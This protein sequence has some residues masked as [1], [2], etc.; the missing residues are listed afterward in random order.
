MAELFPSLL[1]LAQQ[2]LPAAGAEVSAAGATLYGALFRGFPSAYNQQEVLRV[3]HGHLG[4]A[5]RGEASAALGVLLALAQQRL[6][7]GYASFLSSILDHVEGYADAQVEQVYGLFG[8]IVAA[9]CAERDAGGGA[10]GDGSRMEDEL[11]V[12]LRKQLNSTQPGPRRAGVIGAVSLV[13]RLGAAAAEHGAAADET[14]V[15]E[16]CRCTWAADQTLSLSLIASSKHGPDVLLLLPLLHP[17]THP[18]SAGKRYAEAHSMLKNAFQGCKANPESFAFLCDQLTR[19][20]GGE[21]T[22][23]RQGGAPLPCAHAPGGSSCAG[24][25]VETCASLPSL[26]A[27]RCS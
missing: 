23:S 21:K 27:G 14:A 24:N 17:P 22:T 18:L 9:A 4:A 26:G 1:G 6:L 16:A 13:Q 3:L 12:V 8:E 2:L 15:G 5:A 20:V 25:T 19:A 11:F 10:G 7:S